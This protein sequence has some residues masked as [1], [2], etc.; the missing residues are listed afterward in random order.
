[1]VRPL[2]LQAAAEATSSSNA[3]AGA[4]PPLLLLFVAAAAVA[5]V[6]VA[7][8]TSSKNAKPWARQQRRGSSPPAPEPNEEQSGASSFVGKKQLLASLSGVGGG[9]KKQLLASLTGIGGKAA[10]VAKMV[11]WN[12]RSPPAE[13]DW[14]SRASD[15]DGNDHG[16]I[17]EGKEEDAVW[18]KAIIMGDKCRPL[19]FSGQIAYDSDGNRLPPLAAEPIKKTAVAGD[20]DDR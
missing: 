12:K 19:E 5:S 18:K 3:A 16:V 4:A 17:A 9:G 8:C 10:A 13:A 1:M 20:A 7:L 14:S 15:D 11:S 6:V 2:L